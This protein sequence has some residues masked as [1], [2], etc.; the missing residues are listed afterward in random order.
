MDAAWNLWSNP[1]ATV[2]E[3]DEAFIAVE[4]AVASAQ[5]TLTQQVI[6]ATAHLQDVLG[7][8]SLNRDLAIDRFWRNARALASH[9]PA[10]FKARMLGDYGLNG[11][12][13]PVFAPGKDRKST[14]LNSSHV[15]S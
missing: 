4:L 6:D 10:P 7:A 9:N 1:E 15:A 12:L 13:P 3:I 11:T 5:V 14:R 8:S 2:A